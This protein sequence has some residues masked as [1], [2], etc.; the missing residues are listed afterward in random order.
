MR[1][2]RKDGWKE[3]G[4]ERRKEGKKER[5]RKLSAQS[6]L[7]RSNVHKLVLMPFPDN[8]FSDFG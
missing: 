7:K 8:L 1:E 2:R 4:R 3:G 5:G 6:K